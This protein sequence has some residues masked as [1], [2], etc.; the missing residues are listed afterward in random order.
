MGSRCHGKLGIR[1]P[2]VLRD[3]EGRRTPQPQVRGFLLLVS[4][5][6]IFGLVFQGELSE[7]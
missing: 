2:E 1:A 4:I 5:D 6:A 7:V 3:G